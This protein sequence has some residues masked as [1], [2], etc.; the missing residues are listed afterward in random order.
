[1]NVQNKRTNLVAL[2]VNNN[3]VNIFL[4]ARQQPKKRRNPLKTKLVI[5]IF[6]TKKKIDDNLL[7]MLCMFATVKTHVGARQ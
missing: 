1:M 5:H 2:N 6:I 4:E 3:Q 7:N